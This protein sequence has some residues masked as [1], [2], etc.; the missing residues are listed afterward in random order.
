MLATAIPAIAS[1]YSL[2]VAVP[3]TDAVGAVEHRVGARRVEREQGAGAGVGGHHIPSS[4]MAPLHVANSGRT[5]SRNSSMS[6]VSGNFGKTSWMCSKPSSASAAEVVDHRRGFAGERQLIALETRS[7]GPPGG[8]AVGVEKGD[9]RDRSQDR[10]PGPPDRGAVLA[11]DLDL[12]PK[13]L[14]RARHRIPPVAV[15]CHRA[16]RSPAR[17]HHRS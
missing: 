15:R 11:E 7:C 13:R 17:R 5:R 10:R 16:E 9:E 1:R 2:S 12:A 6:E 4:V 14:H 3:D 8:R